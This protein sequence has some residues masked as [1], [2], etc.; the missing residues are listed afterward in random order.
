MSEQNGINKQN[1]I[2]KEILNSSWDGLAIIDMQGKFKFINKAFV[3]LF[4]YSEKELLSFNFSNIIEDEYLEDFSNLLKNNK[5]NSYQNRLDIAC[6]R[7]DGQL[8]FVR[9]SIR[10][11]SNKTMYILNVSD[12]NESSIKEKLSNEY[13]LK[14]DL[15]KDGFILG[16][17]EAFYKTTKYSIQQLAGN[18]YTDILASITVPFQKDALEKNLKALHDWKGK[19]VIQN[20]DGS[21][22]NVDA[23]LQTI[24]N[25]Y[26]DVIA[27]TI[28]MINT[29][30]MD[31][32]E[33]TRLKEMLVDEGEKLE[34]MSD[35]MRTVA[36][37]WRQPLNSISLSAQELIFSLDFDDEVDKENIKSQLE[38]ISLNTENLSKIIEN[39]QSL[40]DLN[41]SKKKRNIKE[42]INE[43]IKIAD[44]NNDV[45][46][47]DNQ[48]TKAF[49][50]Y[51]KELAL[52]I[53]SI[54]TNA[55]EII[56]NIPDKKI[57]VVTY[58]DGANIVCELS[59]NGGHIPQDIIQKI[60][61]PYFSTKDEKNGVG[62]SLYVCKFIIE[63]H[64]KGQIEVENLKDDIV[65]FR[66]KFPKGA[67]E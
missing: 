31:K 32:T 64:L 57:N 12:I 54:L 26:G 41:E 21:N 36:H 51:P 19:L 1:I 38:L 17:S 53:S 62:L 37:Q 20:S 27:Y 61:A 34:I 66:L 60:F 39:F 40:T 45:I 13:L 14:L 42:I 33:Q 9:L 65:M 24:L 30:S 48:E 47:I 3:P 43:A 25:K 7:K 29:S 6:K 10:L 8:I 2:L 67:L 16:A 56:L 46:E 35:T 58:D 15:T 59:N 49:R 50:T 23:I 44:I 28:A 55:K 5:Q 63:L 22:F 11:M 52:A 4:A 18:Y